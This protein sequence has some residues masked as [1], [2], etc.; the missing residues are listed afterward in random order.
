[1]KKIAYMILI[2]AFL[3]C[4]TGLKLVSDSYY[5]QEDRKTKVKTKIPLKSFALNGF[6]IYVF[7]I[8]E[9]LQVD[10]PKDRFCECP[11]D[12]YNSELSSNMKKV[13]E[14]YLLKHK[15]TDLIIYLTT[16]SHKYISQHS[17]FLNDP[18][19]YENNIV[20][21]QIEFAYIGKIDDIE[22]VIHFPSHNDSE[23]IILHYDPQ[24]FSKELL[25]T[26]AN[27]ATAEN[28]YTIFK[29]ISLD[30]VFK[31]Q[32]SYHKRDYSISYY[33]GSNNM[34]S[35][36]PKVVD[37][38]KLFVKKD[39]VELSFSFNN[40]DK[41]YKMSKKRIKYLPNFYLIQEN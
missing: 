21:D 6:D 7:N 37:T 18:K 35:V 17:G 15:K 40:F 32:F 31:Q 9:K 2:L 14:L 1:M 11:S 3:S 12:F 29:P 36:N 38:L 41:D 23:D 5:L 22:N 4:R 16:F 30:K 39:K 26:K 13:E 8:C 27:V 33:H 20:L 25:F 19:F 34:E 24:V 28:N 10:D